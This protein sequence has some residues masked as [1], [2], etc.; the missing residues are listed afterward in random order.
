[1]PLYSDIH[2]EFV[3]KF[4]VRVAAMKVGHGTEAGVT[5]GP[6]INVGG[7]EKVQDHLNDA[8]SKGALVL[9]GGCA[10]FYACA[11]AG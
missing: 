8:V 7:V 1:M 9:T 3:E 6:L 4:A 10:F 2:D 5:I 11:S